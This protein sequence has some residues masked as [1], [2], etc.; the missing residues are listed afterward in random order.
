MATIDQQVAS[1]E[2]RITALEEATALSTSAARLVRAS[3]GGSS[4]DTLAA[5]QVGVQGCW[6]LPTGH[7][8]GRGHLLSQCTVLGG[9]AVAG[10]V[11]QQAVYWLDT[12]LS[13]RPS[14]PSL[15]R[16]TCW[17]S[18]RSCRLRWRRWGPA[19]G[20]LCPARWAMCLLV[21]A[22]KSASLP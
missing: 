4:A 10:I 6:W 13:P 19:S 7:R 17:R 1:S 9:G 20:R 18:S 5:L 21:W 22:G 3:S 8:M 14:A 12:R 11:P 16:A 15:R 2:R